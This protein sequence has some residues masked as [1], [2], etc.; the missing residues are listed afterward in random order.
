MEELSIADDKR[1]TSVIDACIHYWTSEAFDLGFASARICLNMN[2]QCYITLQQCPHHL[3]TSTQSISMARSMGPPPDRWQGDLPSSSRSP[4]GIGPAT[5]AASV[6]DAAN[7]WKYVKGVT[8]GGKG[9]DLY[10][11]LSHSVRDTQYSLQ[12][13][14]VR[15]AQWMSLGWTSAIYLV[16]QYELSWHMNAKLIIPGTELCILLRSV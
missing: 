11:L 6:D 4:A 5:S 14:G 16:M 1:C 13:P 7:A 15:L 3:L 10:D 2:G 8:D 12:Y 9:V